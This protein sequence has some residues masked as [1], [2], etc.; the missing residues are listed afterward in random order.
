MK[1]YHGTPYLF[2]AFTLD[3]IAE[4][5]GIKFGAGV[6][7]TEEYDTAV[8]YSSPRRQEAEHNYIYTV[9]VPNKTEF[10]FLPYPSPVQTEIVKRVEARLK[11]TV[12]EIA[13]SKGKLFRKYLAHR[14]VG[15]PAERLQKLSHIESATKL[16]GEM[17]AS[18]ALLEAGV[19]YI[20][21][22]QGSWTKYPE[23]T[24]NYAVLDPSVIEILKVEE[25]DRQEKGKG[26]FVAASSV[27]VTS[28]VV[29]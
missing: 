17:L 21:W 27:D 5:S 4:G 19:I 12:P 22:P 29:W 13:K 11:E 26:R 2:R 14:L 9:E 20:E 18:Q 25:I 16:E 10:N 7:L 3:S 24:K 8:L 28:E 6:Y 1:L 15:V 23:C